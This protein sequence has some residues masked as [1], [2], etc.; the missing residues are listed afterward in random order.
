MNSK[1]TALILIGYQNDYF[2]PQ[3]ALYSVIEEP[4]RLAETLKNT[5]HVVEDLAPTGM[6]IVTTPIVFTPDYSE[7]IDP[8]GILKAVQDAGA[9]K[10][11][12]SGSAIIP[13]L[14]RFADQICEVPGKRGLNAFSNTQLDQVLKDREIQHIVMVGAVTSI[15]I[16]ST[17]RAAFERGYKVTILSDCVSGR[18]RF[19]EDFYRAQIFP[20]YAEVLTSLEFLAKLKPAV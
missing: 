20:L 15:C 14:R 9:F 18:T 8:V 2:S 7:L 10:A 19:E 16:D 3:G 12:S 6:L 17:A 1:D 5:L 13:Q 4:G 11:G